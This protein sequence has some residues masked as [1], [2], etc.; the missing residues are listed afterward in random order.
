V[1]PELADGSI[2]PSA[3]IDNPAG[4]AE[5]VPPVV[6]VWLT[7]TGPAVVQNGPPV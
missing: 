4:A 1:P 7:G 6:P 3:A 2:V 5:Y